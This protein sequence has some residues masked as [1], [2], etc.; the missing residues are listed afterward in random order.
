M[1]SAR[2]GRL[3]RAGRAAVVAP[4]L[5]ALALFVLHEPEVAGFAVFGTFIQL[6]MTDYASAPNRCVQSATLSFLGAI[7][8][9]LATLAS[10]NV[11]LAAGGALA[12]GVLS[13]SPWATHGPGAQYRT[14]LL[15]AF[16]LGVAAPSSASALAPRLAGWFLAGLAAQPILWLLWVPVTP[17]NEAAT[18][19]TPQPARSWIASAAATGAAMALAVVLTRRL[20]L[21]HAFWV[22]LGALP[23]VCGRGSR[24]RTFLEQQAGT[25]VGC[26]IGALLLGVLGARTALYW[27]A[28]PVTV[29]AAAYASNAVGFMAAQAAFTVF[30]VVLFCILQPNSDVGALRVADIAIGGALSLATVSL[31]W[32][33]QVRLRDAQ[34]A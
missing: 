17:A 22:F 2:A 25:L 27:A 23:I 11:W 13:E 30:A 31:R 15:L 20:G 29:F 32:L 16:M 34:G 8:I 12:A 3:V 4:A 18:A 14:A 33:A 21:N 9:G 19:V 10:G 24:A 26:L 1:A 6:V 5:F 28:L 7:A